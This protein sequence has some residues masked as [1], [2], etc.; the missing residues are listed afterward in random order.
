MA[1]SKKAAGKGKAKKVDKPTTSKTRSTRRARSTSAEQ[2]APTR[3]SRARSKSIDPEIAKNSLFGLPDPE[4]NTRKRRKG[5]AP[6][7]RASSVATT[8]TDPDPDREADAKMTDEPDVEPDRVQYPDIDLLDTIAVAPVASIESDVQLLAEDKD[9]AQAESSDPEVLSEVFLAS[10]T[11][12]TFTAAVNPNIQP[13]PAVAYPALNT[14]LEAED[15]NSSTHG[16][17]LAPP[18]YDHLHVDEFQPHELSTVAEEEEESTFAYLRSDPN[19]RSHAAQESEDEDDGGATPRPNRPDTHYP[20]RDYPE[21]YSPSVNYGNEGGDLSSHYTPASAHVSSNLQDRFRHIAQSESEEGSDIES[22]DYPE[23]R[24]HLAHDPI[25][26]VEDMYSESGDERRS[27]F[28]EEHGDGVSSRFAQADEAEE[29]DNLAD[30]G[31]PRLR[32]HQSYNLRQQASHYQQQPTSFGTSKGE[33]ISIDSSGDEDSPRRPASANANQDPIVILD[34]DDD[35]AIP[36]PVASSNSNAEAIDVDDA[37]HADTEIETQQQANE[38]ESSQIGS[39]DEEEPDL[40]AATPQDT[41]SRPPVRWP[42]F[43]N[44][45]PRRTPR[46]QFGSQTPATPLFSEGRSRNAGQ[47]NFAQTRLEPPS[48]PEEE[49]LRIDNLKGW[50]MTEEEIERGKCKY[51]LQDITTS[52]SPAP[53]Y[54]LRTFGDVELLQDIC[55]PD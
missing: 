23:N 40:V 50:G 33:V 22:D 27:E 32:R 26:E 39:V 53:S 11:H 18:Q 49:D 13:S 28:S 2:P 14:Q 6:S 30:Y 4:Q 9:S 55:R 41:P 10:S 35:S 19:R 51:S 17:D 48:S 3:P 21:F 29:S 15:D 5:R 1:P 24:D 31:A 20:S 44:R 42:G 8:A 36:Q 54:T 7:S 43:R 47:D 52:H 46:R 45:S 38:A 12:T 25:V 37:M 16:S 34:S